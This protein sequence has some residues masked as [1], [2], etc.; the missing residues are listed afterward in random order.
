MKNAAVVD[1]AGEEEEAVIGMIVIREVAVT[2]AVGH[3][4]M[5][6]RHETP[7]TSK[8]HRLLRTLML[9]RSILSLRLTDGIN[10]RQLMDD[11]LIHITN[12]HRIMVE[13]PDGRIAPTE[14]LHRYRAEK[15]LLQSYLKLDPSKLFR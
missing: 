10:T 7:I 3:L 1:T 12:T 5:P 8:L 13:A 4:H 2:P 14:M 6:L 11:L 9:A 15:P